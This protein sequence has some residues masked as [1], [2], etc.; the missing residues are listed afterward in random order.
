MGTFLALGVVAVFPA[1]TIFYLSFHAWQLG[2]SSVQWV[3]LENF[4][5]LITDERFIDAIWHTIYFVGGGVSVQLLLGL[6]I[7]LLLNRELKG[8]NFYRIAILLPMMCMP[9]AISMIWRIM[10]NRTF[11]VLT[12]LVT[13][14]GFA[15]I[16]WLGTKNLA[17]PALLMVDVWQW[18]PFIMIILLAG[19]QSLPKSCFEA[20]VI[21][22]ASRTQTFFYVTLPLMKF[23]IL[24]A[25]ILR[26][27]L[28]F[29]VFDKVWIITE[30]G[31]NFASE[32]LNVYAYTQA[33][34]YFRFGYACAVG[35]A[36]SVII[37]GMTIFQIRILRGAG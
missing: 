29:K 1:I 23:H 22:G 8:K 17:I 25:L 32:T 14:L 2:I 10:Y 6:G 36:F 16:N 12:Y 5:E 33:F 18:T 26:S 15:P 20:A 11:G 9:S 13:H 37:L 19:L 4:V 27:I 34:L 24:A 30:A 31:P 28:S 3:G 35:I 21:D 7:A